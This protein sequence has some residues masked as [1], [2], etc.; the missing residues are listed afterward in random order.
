MTVLVIRSHR[1][2]A[3]RR[4]VRISRDKR[5][6]VEALMIELSSQGCRLSGLGRAKLEE[7]DAVTLQ[8]SADLQ[9][10][11]T[12]RWAHDGL[13]GLKLDR[14]LYKQEMEEVLRERESISRYGT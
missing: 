11:A 3:T 6:T 1:R 10:P 2:Y 5:R 13:A 4:V 14:T 7:G 12:V 8:L 9:W